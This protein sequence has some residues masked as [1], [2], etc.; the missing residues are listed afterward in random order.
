MLDI[1]VEQSKNY[2]RPKVKTLTPHKSL[3]FKEQ[4]K[5]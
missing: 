5:S 1:Q 4:V 3:Y 2:W